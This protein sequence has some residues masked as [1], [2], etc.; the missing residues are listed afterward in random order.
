MGENYRPFLVLPGGVKIAMPRY[1]KKKIFNDN[2]MSIISCTF[3]NTKPV[4]RSLTAYIA[5]NG[6]DEGYDRSQHEAKKAALSAFRNQSLK[7]RK[8]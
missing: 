5:R 4:D 3:E 8:L 7:S 1:Y 2:Q 6:S